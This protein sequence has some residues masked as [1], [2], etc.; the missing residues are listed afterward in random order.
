MRI[1]YSVE[2]STDRA[3]LE[4]LRRRWCPHAQLI[5]G[6][7]RGTSGQSQRR[8]IPKTCIELTA[9]GVDLIVFLRD[10]NDEDWRDVLREDEK[11]CRSDHEHLAV[12][13]VCDRNVECWL[14]TDRDW[15]AKETGRQAK[16]FDVADPKAPFE[17]ALGITGF[18]CR[19]RNRHLVAMSP[20]FSYALVVILLSF[21]E[22]GFRLPLEPVFI[23]YAAAFL[24]GAAS[25]GEPDDSGG[26]AA[27]PEMEGPRSDKGTPSDRWA[28]TGENT[29]RPWKVALT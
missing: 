22:S 17:K 4:G 16:D 9:K 28:A 5:E 1:G 8:E 13:A 25:S 11:R 14:C 29:S 23:V 21:T 18:V 6:R 2:G 24:A 12:F 10:A 26:K 3:S 7:F 15:I 20:L 19:W 27:I